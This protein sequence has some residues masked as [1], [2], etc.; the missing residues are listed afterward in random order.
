[1]LD[2]KNIKGAIFDVDDTLL[3][4]QPDSPLGGLHERSRLRALYKIGKTH[5]YPELLEVTPLENRNAFRE[6]KSHTLDAAVWR[7]LYTRGIVQTED[8]DMEN[9]LLV[10]IVNLKDKFHEKVLRREGREV[11]GATNF[12]KKLGDRGLKNN[13]AI[14]STAVRRDINIFLEM[15]GLN[16]YFPEGRII[17]KEKVTH[18][19][20]HPEVFNLAFE[21]LKLPDELRS[22]VLAFEDDPRGVASAKSAGLF[23]CAI[24]T[25]YK[26]E[27]FASFNIQ[28]DLIADNYLEFEKFFGL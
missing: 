27:A 23:T 25:R 1:M 4:N 19:K 6:A 20:P 7:I 22:S 24:T 9:E 13:M 11:V 16:I 18:P 3:D 2:V 12:V 5:G 17:S 28:P 15:T 10:T 21:S 26:K 8:I 14:A